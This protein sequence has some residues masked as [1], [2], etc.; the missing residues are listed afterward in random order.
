MQQLFDADEIFSK[1][2][3]GAKKPVRGAAGTGGV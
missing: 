1:A 2:R 3:A